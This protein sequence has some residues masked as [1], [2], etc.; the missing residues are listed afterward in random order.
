MYYGQDWSC[1]DHY[2]MT[3][4]RHKMKSW[5]KINQ[6]FADSKKLMA[7]E[8]TYLDHDDVSPEEA[9]AWALQQRRKKSHR[10]LLA[11]KGFLLNLLF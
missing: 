2:W 1:C 5:Q 8:E 4:E 3:G 7:L 10:P 6:V 9:R 11:L